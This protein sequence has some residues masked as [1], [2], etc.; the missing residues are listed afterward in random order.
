L[1]RTVSTRAKAEAE[2]VV[3]ESSRAVSAR[4]KV[5]V[6]AAE[7]EGEPLESS[8]VGEGEG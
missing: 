4:A 6:V 3:A 1:G 2:V 5:E 7:V 8:C